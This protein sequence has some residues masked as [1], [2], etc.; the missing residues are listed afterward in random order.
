MPPRTHTNDGKNKKPDGEA[1]AGSKEYTSFSGWGRNVIL[2]RVSDLT[3][4]PEGITV[5]DSLG[6]SPN[7]TCLP[8]AN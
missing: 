8:D 6:F 5:T 3:L 1:P 7:S 4:P 2:V